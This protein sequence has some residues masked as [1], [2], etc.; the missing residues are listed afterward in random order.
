[1]KSINFMKI[2]L[3]VFFILFLT[4]CSSIQKN[5]KTDG[6]TIE[7]DIALSKK[8]GLMFFS[9][10][11]TDPQSKNLLEMFLRTAYFQR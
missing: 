4:S 8:Q 10:S 2:C 11:D 9:A 5:W 7:K 1:M 3:F 6:S